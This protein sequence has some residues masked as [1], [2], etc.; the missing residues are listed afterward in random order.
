MITDEPLLSRFRALVTAILPDL[1][2]YAVHEYRVVSGTAATGFLLVAES[3]TMPDLAGAELWEAREALTTLLPGARVLVGFRGGDRAKPYIAAD[4]TVMRH[5][6]TV[7]I[8]GSGP[9]AGVIT[10]VPP[11]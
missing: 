3:Q 4:P 1:R 7:A 9:A 2:F 11:P 10:K 5:G 6:E 8:S